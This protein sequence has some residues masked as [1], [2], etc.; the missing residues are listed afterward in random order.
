LSDCLIAGDSFCDIKSPFILIGITFDRAFGSD[1]LGLNDHFLS[2]RLLIDHSDLL[3]QFGFCDIGILTEVDLFESAIIFIIFRFD[4][5][6]QEKS[7]QSNA[8]IHEIRFQ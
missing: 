6:Q 7:F 3:T 1:P 2:S 5:I 8:V 4:D